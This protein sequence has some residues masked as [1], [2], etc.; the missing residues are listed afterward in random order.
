[1]AC[2]GS[3]Y[4]ANPEGN[5]FNGIRPFSGFVSGGTD[6]EHY[7][8]TKPNE[9]YFTGLDHIVMLAAKHGILT[10]LDL[11]E[12]AGW[13]PTLRKNDLTAAYTYGQYLG[14]RYRHFPN[15]AWLN[16]NDF[17]N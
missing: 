13:L 8:L 11:A 16:G 6:S 3:D 9:A 5:A 1:M 10:F 17:V 15:V 12:T 4:P 7:D 14:R 2:T